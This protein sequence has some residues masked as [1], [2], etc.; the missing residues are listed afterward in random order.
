MAAMGAA[1]GRLTSVRLGGLQVVSALHATAD[2][3]QSNEDYGTEAFRKVRAICVHAPRTAP[4][5]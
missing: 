1:G 2:Y 5:L 4:W 3:I